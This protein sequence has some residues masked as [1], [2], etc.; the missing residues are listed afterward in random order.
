MHNILTHPI[1]IDEVLSLAPNQTPVLPY[2]LSSP[3]PSLLME[4]GFP[5]FKTHHRLP[6]RPGRKNE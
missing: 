4:T 2:C 1:V 6:I 5:M 3:Y